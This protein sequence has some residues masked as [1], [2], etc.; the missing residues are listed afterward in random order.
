MVSKVQAFLILALVHSLHQYLAYGACRR[1]QIAYAELSKEKTSFATLVVAA[2]FSGVGGGAFAS[3][4]SNISFFFPKAQ[5][6][7]GLGLNAGIGNLGV[8]LSQVFC[9]MMMGYAAF[10][11]PR[12]MVSRAGVCVG[13]GARVL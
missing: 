5:Q 9:P 13:A 7:L 8:S 4:M 3:S 10:G 6:G 11:K 1:W 12:V 2:M